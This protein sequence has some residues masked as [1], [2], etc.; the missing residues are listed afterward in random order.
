MS[1][2]Q[3]QP[4]P[5]WG[6]PPPPPKKNRW[7]KILGIGCGG[8]VG[9]FV[10]ALAIGAAVGPPEDTDDK[11]KPAPKTSTSAPPEPAS[12]T[13]TSAGLSERDI[14]RLSVDMVWD[15]YT[16]PQRDVLCAGVEA[17][18]PGWFADQLESDN[19]DRDYAGQL[20]EEKCAAR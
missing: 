5:A 12:P 8:I 16:E 1:Y 2:P 18:G 7:K 4:P 10:I 19:L 14:T 3:Y 17:N 11:S 9:F 6:P 13:P 15:G 20:V